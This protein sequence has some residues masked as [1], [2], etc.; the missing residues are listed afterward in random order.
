MLEKFSGSVS[1]KSS[2]NA[3]VNEGG[4]LK[5]GWRWGGGSILHRY[6]LRAPGEPPGYNE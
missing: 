3:V 2:A 1:P 4:A 5:N 6:G